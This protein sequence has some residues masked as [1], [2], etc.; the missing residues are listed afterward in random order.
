MIKEK[1]EV[2]EL[3]QVKYDELFHDL[4]NENEM[5]TIEWIAM[6]ILNCSYEDIHG[7]VEVRNIR[8][9]RVLKN[10]R[11]KFVDLIVN[12]KNETIILELNNNF[13]GNYTRN[14]MYAFNEL[15]SYFGH[16][17]GS[18]YKKIHRVVLIN[19]NWFYKGN[20]FGLPEKQE[21]ELPYPNYLKQGYILKV[22][23]INLDRYNELCYNQVKE[24]DKFY[25]LLTID[26]ESDLSKLTKDEKLLIDYSTKLKDLSSDNNYKEKVMDQRIEDNLAR[27]EGYFEGI[28]EGILQGIEKGKKEN[29]KE[30]VLNMYNNK[31]SLEMISKCTSLTIDE[32][33]DII[34]LKN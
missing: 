25:K 5:N 29:Q 8:K 26:N 28:D 6:Q 21:F 24:N 23:N 11:N 19:L 7:K 18:Y 13:K 9:Q 31:I 10:E 3:L 17:E 27:Q 20:D 22:V 14:L 4:I 2:K 34:S 1:E 15:L 33:N 30:I 32:I 12:F 16:D